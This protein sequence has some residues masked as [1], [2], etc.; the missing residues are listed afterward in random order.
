AVFDAF[1][2]LE[3]IGELNMWV[4][5]AGIVD[6]R[7]EEDLKAQV[8]T[9]KNL[10]DTYN[11]ELFKITTAGEIFIDGV[12]EGLTARLLEPYEEAAG[13]GPDYYGIYYWEDMGALKEAFK[14]LNSAGFQIHI[15]AIGD[16]AVR[17]ALDA[18]EYARI[19]VP[20]DHR[21]AITHLQLVSTD[22]VSRFKELGIIANV[23]VFWH[24]K[25]PGW[26]EYVDA[27][28]L[29][30]R[31]KH[32]YPLGSLFRA[33][34]VVVSSSDHPVTPIPNPLWGIKVGVTRNLS[35]AEFYGVED[36]ENVDDPTWLL[37]KE[38]RV[39]LKDMIKSFSA[40]NAYSLF[41]D[42]KTGTIALGKYAD[43]VILEEDLFVINP[44]RIDGVKI[45]KTIFRGKV[46][47]H[48]EK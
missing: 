45:L 24:L 2:L 25:E 31:A 3:E 36:I 1:K 48:A 14:L 12:V 4:R 37:N 33:G 5:G 11:S 28:F 18:L 21:N 39:S 34:A 46:V 40:N 41:L 44:L 27:P 30:E 15:H 16:R 13:K 29:G 26:W 17:D 47:Y 8:E 42:D 32:Q 19:S 20:G 7:R 9:L 10:R 23:Q 35:N 22:D 43:L 6:I 38:E